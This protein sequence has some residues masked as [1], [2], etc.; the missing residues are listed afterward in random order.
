MTRTLTSY[1]MKNA[2]GPRVVYFLTVGRKKW[3]RDFE[4]KARDTHLRRS[5]NVGAVGRSG[6]GTAE[7]S[8]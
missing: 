3:T 1:V 2:F 8:S 7:S 4:E 5:T 6:I